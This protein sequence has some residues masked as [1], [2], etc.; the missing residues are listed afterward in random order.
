MP[1]K[2]VLIA[3]SSRPPIGE[4]L[5]KAFGRRGV[6]A[7]V[8]HSDENTRF[9]RHVIH[10]VNKTLH[11]LRLLSKKSDLFEDHPLKHLNFRS[12]M[13]VEAVRRESPD[14]V[15][16]IRGIRFREDALREVRKHAKVFGWWIERE[17][18]M[19]EAFA[20]LPLYDRYFFMN[21]SSVEEGK[22]RGVGSKIS[23]LHHSVDT[24]EFRPVETDKRYDWSFVGS[25][26]EKRQAYIER[27]LSVSSNCAIY[28]PKWRKKNLFNTSIRKAVKGNYIEGE[29]LRSLYSGSKVVI[30][31]TNWGFGE[32]AA[33][34]GLNMRVLEVPACRACLLTDGS[35]DLEKVVRPGTHVA[36]YE[37][38]DDFAKKLERL[39]KDPGERERIARDGFLHVTSAYTY[40]S[41]AKVLTEHYEVA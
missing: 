6:T 16:V 7:S 21:S 5:A 27:A 24:D 35:R 4:Y 40:D 13:L 22:R 25:W 15:L 10:T 28:G 41:V 33:R 37:G 23:L 3:Y 34:S 30:N 29:A 11:N 18:R 12:S 39:L 36:V 19:D 20:E 26:S 32:G 9:D 31:V 17:E 1:L 2:K 8:F 14:L 38:V